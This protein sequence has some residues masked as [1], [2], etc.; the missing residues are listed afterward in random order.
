VGAPASFFSLKF[1]YRENSKI[2]GILVK[3]RIIGYFR[4]VNDILLVFQNNVTNIQEVLNTFNNLTHTMHF[5]VVEYVDNKINFRYV[6]PSATDFIIPVDSCHPIEHKIAA[7]R[8]LTNRL[9]TYPTNETYK[10]NKRDTMKDILYNNKYYTAG[11]N[12]NIRTNDAQEQKERKNT[13]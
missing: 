4:Y 10:R 9:S 12:K 8:Y 1:I 7:V 6:I 2:F 3:H 5:T 11:L 13:Y